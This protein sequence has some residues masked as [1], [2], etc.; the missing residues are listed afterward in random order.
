MAIWPTWLSASAIG[1]EQLSAGHADVHRTP[2]GGRRLRARRRNAPCPAPRQAAVNRARPA[3]HPPSRATNPADRRCAP[4]FGPA[5]AVA[6]PPEMPRIRPAPRATPCRRGMPA[7]PACGA[8][9]WFIVHSRYLPKS[10][11]PRCGRAQQRHA[12]AVAHVQPPLAAH[13]P[14]FHRRIEDSHEDA[15]GRVAGHDCLKF[16]PIRCCIA[17]AAR[18][19]FMARSTLRAASSFK[20]QFFAMPSSSSSA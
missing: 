12:Q 11:K 15:L 10:K 9:G 3:C 6:P 4:E 2:N 20:V 16:S 1:L 5:C 14:A 7:S 13:Q 19:L 8:I 18:R 17:T